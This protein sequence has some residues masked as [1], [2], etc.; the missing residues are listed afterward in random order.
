[1]ATLLTHY[2]EP[3]RRA[4]IPDNNGSEDSE[5]DNRLKKKKRMPIQW[6]VFL[7][8]AII[9]SDGMKSHEHGLVAK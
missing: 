9:V 6:Q 5:V 3:N 8:P 1:M 2:F 7:L 4:P